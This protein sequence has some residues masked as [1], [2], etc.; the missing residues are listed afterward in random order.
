[1]V[2][3]S[4]QNQSQ[5]NR[6]DARGDDD[7]QCEQVGE[8]RALG[9]R[10]DQTGAPASGDRF[11]HL[12]ERRIAT[13][14]V[15]VIR[16]TIELSAALLTTAFGRS[17]RAATRVSISSIKSGSERMQRAVAIAHSSTGILR[18]RSGLPSVASAGATSLIDVVHANI[19]ET[20]SNTR[21]NVTACR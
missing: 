2:T 4:A 15:V 14:M 12:A 13:D 19:S 1:M 6:A 5:N 10:R 20:Q 18:N 3:R 7:G 11:T 21:P 17:R 16:S 9:V 8:L